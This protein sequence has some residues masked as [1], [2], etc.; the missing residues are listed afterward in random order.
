MRIP[1][2]LLL[3]ALVSATVGLTAGCESVPKPQAY[4]V[5]V[6]L[7]DS[8]KDASLE[9]DLVGVDASTSNMLANKSVTDYFRPGDATRASVMRHTMKFRREDSRRKT[10]SKS[11]PTWRKWLD[12]GGE[13]LFVIA[14][15]PGSFQD[16]PGNADPRRVILSLMN[17]QWETAEF[18][19][20]LSKGFL[21]C[22]TKRK[23]KKN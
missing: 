17:D 8:L 14:F 13:Q 20:T 16:S 6:S 2:S 5:I 7:D 15:L 12:E 18:K 4:D 22:T 3:S 10:L 21:K 11:D 23:P 1:S 9:V 19:I